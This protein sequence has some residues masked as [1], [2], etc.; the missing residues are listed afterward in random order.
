MLRSFFS[1]KT[2]PRS[3]Q[4]LPWV[5]PMYVYVL[6]Q[7]VS[8]NDCIERLDYRDVNIAAGGPR[9]LRVP[10]SRVTWKQDR[11][12]KEWGSAPN[13]HYGETRYFAHLLYMPSLYSPLGTPANSTDARLCFLT[14]IRVSS[15]DRAISVVH[16]LQTASITAY[17]CICAV[18]RS[19]G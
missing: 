2:F 10:K 3:P 15:R 8:T 13:N 19:V 9:S 1:Q 14:V 4:R 17:S 16:M 5:G 18:V 12:K 7:S 6:S 11:K